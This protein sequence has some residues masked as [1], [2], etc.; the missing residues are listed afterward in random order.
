MELKHITHN[1]AVYR[2]K[3]KSTVFALFSPFGM[4]GHP[5]VS[6]QEKHNFFAT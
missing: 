2:G 6:I 3:Q 1:L 5:P 4:L